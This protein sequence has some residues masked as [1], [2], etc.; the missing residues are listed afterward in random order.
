MKRASDMNKI[1]IRGLSTV[2]LCLAAGSVGAADYYLAARAYTKTMPDLS[3]VPMWGYV[4]DVGGAC[5]NAVA[6]PPGQTA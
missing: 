3:T 5:Y 6:N 4:E 2:A 1:I